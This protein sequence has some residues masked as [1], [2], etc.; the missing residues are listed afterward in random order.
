MKT[1]R[2]CE[3]GVIGTDGKIRL[4]MDRLR[5]FFIA[6]KG[7]RVIV[8]F[9]A[10]AHGS[11]ELQLAYYY[12]YV[13]PAIQIALYDTGERMNAK[14]VDQWLREQCPSIFERFIPATDEQAERGYMGCTETKDVRDLSVAEMAEYLAWI[15][16][17]AAENLYVYIEDPRTL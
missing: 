12:K 6:N 4:P 7:R 13:I 2:I 15:K 3:S 11:S 14:Q 5:A 1:N 16:Q 9:E 10:A 8:E 17:F